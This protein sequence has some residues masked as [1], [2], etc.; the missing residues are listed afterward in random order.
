MSL[1]NI[2]KSP[3]T[4]KHIWNHTEK[5]YKRLSHWLFSVTHTVNVSHCYSRM[6]SH[7]NPTETLKHFQ[8]YTHI[9]CP[10]NFQR[11]SV[12]SSVIFSV[13]IL[14]VNI[15]KLV[16]HGGNLT[17][18]SSAFNTL[19]KSLK[20]STRYCNSIVQNT[21]TFLNGHHGHCIVVLSRTMWA[22]GRDMH[23]FY[24]QYMCTV[25]TDYVSEFKYTAVPRQK[26]SSL[27]SLPTISF[28]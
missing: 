20:F 26:D 19:W 3:T 7:F 5:L 11:Y 10:L 24:I 18:H 4:Q 13:I 16:N 8:R 1:K 25:V 12:F 15:P 28:A 21:Y 22:S 6:W 9:L 2:L 17:F 23:L 27:V 14:I